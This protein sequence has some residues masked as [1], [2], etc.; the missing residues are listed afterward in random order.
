MEREYAARQFA[1]FKVPQSV[2]AGGE[3]IV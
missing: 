3:G 2:A 1:F